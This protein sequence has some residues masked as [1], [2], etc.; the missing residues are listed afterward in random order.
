MAT[1]LAGEQARAAADLARERE[2]ASAEVAREK[3]RSAAALKTVVAEKQAALAAWRER[4]AQ[5]MNKL[6]EQTRRGERLEQQLA[7]L[8][9]QYRT[10][11]R[12][13]KTA[14]MDVKGE[15]EQL[16][17]YLE[18]KMLAQHNDLKGLK[19][20]LEQSRRETIEQRERKREVVQREMMLSKE[21]KKA[22][23]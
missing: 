9:E 7:V 3:A 20:E 6:A 17:M 2:R 5:L 8:D 22:R 11:K 14:L 21:L 13:F 15:R 10:A 4:E 1:E 23:S 16:K 12:E 19:D 18:D